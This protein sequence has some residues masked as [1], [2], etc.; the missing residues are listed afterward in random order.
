M[1]AFSSMLFSCDTMD[2]ETEMMGDVAGT[3]VQPD[4]SETVLPA[5][6]PPKYATGVVMLPVD[7]VYTKIMM[8]REQNSCE[9][10]SWTEET[11]Q[12]PASGSSFLPGSSRESTNHNQQ[13]QKTGA[14]L[15][16]KNPPEA[17]SINCV[18][19]EYY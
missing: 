2:G 18:E 11:V 17:D 14:T 6:P 19:R 5:P 8:E 12:N 4:S 7:T 16:K 9:E 3:E 13:T 15:H 1:L 10:P